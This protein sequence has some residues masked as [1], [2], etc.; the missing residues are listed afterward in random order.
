VVF[1]IYKI[2]GDEKMTSTKNQINPDE[3]LTGDEL[4]RKLKV[5]KSFLYAPER[6][7]GPNAIPCVR[8][9]KYLRYDLGAV[10]VWIE[11]QNQGQE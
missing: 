2:K 8:I 5:K 10:R 7:R 4:C 3:L 9:G 6:R 11:R 1:F